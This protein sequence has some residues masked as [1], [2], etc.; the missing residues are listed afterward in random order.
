[1]FVAVTLASVMA[2]GATGNTSVKATPVTGTPLLLDSVTVRVVVPPEAI[3][4]TPKAFA[5]VG[6]LSTVSVWF[7]TPLSIPPMAVTWAAPFT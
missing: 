3:D 6:R 5:T 1:M 4:A 2:P 7:V